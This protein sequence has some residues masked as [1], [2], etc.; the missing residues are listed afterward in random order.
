METLLQPETKYPRLYSEWQVG[1]SVV[2]A[3][4]LAGGW[5]LRRNFQEL[6]ETTRARNALIASLA[7]TVALALLPLP[8]DVSPNIV[9]IPIALGFL[10]AYKKLMGSRYEDELE[11]GG[12]KQGFWK[13]FGVAVFSIPFTVAIV[14]FVMLLIPVPPIN[15]VRYENNFIYYEQNAKREDA[16]ALANMLRRLDVLS[17][18]SEWAITLSFPRFA[19]DRVIIEFPVAEAPEKNSEMDQAFKF[20]QGNL[21]STLYSDKSEVWI[22]LTDP[23]G[24]HL[25]RIPNDDSA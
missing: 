6:G 7:I 10:F 16:E 9:S 19:P 8:T 24:F 21:A 17:A 5:L 1:F 20:L 25:V 23:F 22:S 18:Q 14:I 15:N 13:T 11:R 2:L 4:P 3:G 12:V